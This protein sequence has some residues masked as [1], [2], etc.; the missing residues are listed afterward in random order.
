MKRILY[1]GGFELPDK[2]PAA[3]R[4]LSIAKAW[5][6]AGIE[7]FFLGVS[8]SN[9]E[10]NVLETKENIQ[11][12][13]TYSIPYPN[14]KSEWI[15]YLTNVSSVERLIELLGEI[16][17]VV[18]Y[19]Y[20]AVAF[21]R[22][23]RYCKKKNIKIY[24]DCTEWYN[25]DG[26]NL[27]FKVLKGFD[28]WYRMTVVQKRLDGIIAISSYLKKYYSSCRNVI[29]IPPLVDIREE[30]WQVKEIELGE[31][32]NFIYAGQP[33]NKDKI[34]EIVS[35]YKEI[36]KRYDGKLWVVGISK[37]QFLQSYPNFTDEELPDSV[38]FLGRLTHE[39]SLAYLKAADCS[40]I[41]RDSNRMNNAGF[42]TKFVEA[43]TVGTSVIAT[44]I[45]D[46]QEYESDNVTIVHGSL[47]DAMEDFVRTYSQIQHRKMD[48]TFDYR[49]WETKILEF[50][51][52]ETD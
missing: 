27:V 14:K 15:N 1:V 23:R 28:T 32:F 2:N 48:D 4:V 52:E 3:H 43:L 29:Q 18:C 17:C 35:A 36:A 31:T 10:S 6:D 40:L 39:Q 47:K 19:N 20:Q 51:Y 41:I 26:T 13:S 5:R 8:K 49:K 16:D 7:V 45:S 24:S 50:L 21:E 12:F 22:L 44:D 37:Q 42:P 11:G 25:T 38:I 33:G 9:R 46:L 30:K 34:D